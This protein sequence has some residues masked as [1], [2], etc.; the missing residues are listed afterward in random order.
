MIADGLFAHFPMDAI[1]ALHNRPG[2]ME[3]RF[4]V[5]AG[6]V[7]TSCDL[8][9]VLVRGRSAHAALPHQ[10]RDAIVA[11]AAMVTALQTMVSRSVSPLEFL[12]A[13]ITHFDGGSAW[14]VLPETAAFEGTIRTYRAEVRDEAEENL[15]R[16][17][18]GVAAA[19]GVA[20]ELSFERRCPATINFEQECELAAMTARTVAGLEGLDQTLSPGCGSDDFAFMLDRIP[21]AYLWIG[22]GKD[23]VGLHDPTY[24]FNDSIL[25]Q[26]IG[27]WSALVERALRPL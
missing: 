24:V 26:G 7:M 12:V 19:M 6:A 17:V 8:F 18:T 9:H 27:F 1:F 13:S 11:A 22:N 23:S 16:I 3:G 14:N 5:R 15:R 25:E 2:L 10:G 20:V 4:G 21:G